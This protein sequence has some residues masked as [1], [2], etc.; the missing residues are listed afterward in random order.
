[1][2]RLLPEP[3]VELG[4][5]VKCGLLFGVVT[6]AAKAARELEQ[7][8]GIPSRTLTRLTDDLAT[9]VLLATRA[10]VMVAPAMNP[11]IN[12]NLMDIVDSSPGR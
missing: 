5:A 9:C 3:L 1:M 12:F 11:R 8:S 10:P 4:E 6:V 2:L 7:S